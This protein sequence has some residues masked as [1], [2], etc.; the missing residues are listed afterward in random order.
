MSGKIIEN[1]CFLPSHCHLMPPIQETPANVCIHL[2]LLETKVTLSTCQFVWNVPLH[3]FPS[4][5][6]GRWLSTFFIVWQCGSWHGASDGPTT[7]WRRWHLC[8]C[9]NN[10]S[11]CCI[12]RGLSMSA[13]VCTLAVGLDSA[14]VLSGLATPPS[15]STTQCYNS[16]T[17]QDIILQLDTFLCRH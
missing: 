7:C 4:W 11:C 8:A 10:T 1:L 2:R 9:S 17:L 16:T 3:D 14:P 6:W 13:G 12:I 5:Q 15:Y